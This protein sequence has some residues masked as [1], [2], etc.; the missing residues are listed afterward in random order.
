MIVHSVLSIA[1]I[2]GVLLIFKLIFRHQGYSGVLTRK[3]FKKGCV[4]ILPAALLALLNL[5][6]T[7]F[8]NFKIGILLLGF[9]PA[10]TE[11]IT[12]RAMI[13]PNFLRI[14]NKPAGI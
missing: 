10:F 13:V 3:N 14:Y 6:G 4:I 9:V 5:L 2:L 11:E 1:I 12:F 8:G 7:N